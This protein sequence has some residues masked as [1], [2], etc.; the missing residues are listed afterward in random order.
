MNN[1]VFLR[2]TIE[3]DHYRVMTVLIQDRNDKVVKT[4]S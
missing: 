2:G 3:T 1:T 4:L